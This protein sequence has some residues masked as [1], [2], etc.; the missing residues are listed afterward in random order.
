MGGGGGGGF[1]CMCSKFV[2]LDVNCNALSLGKKRG[3]GM[4]RGKK[5][6]CN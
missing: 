3:G 1:I 6:N 4:V 2:F 5:K